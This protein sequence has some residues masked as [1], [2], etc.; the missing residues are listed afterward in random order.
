MLGSAISQVL[1]LAGGMHQPSDGWSGLRNASIAADQALLQEEKSDNFDHES[2]EFLC[3]LGMPSACDAAQQFRNETR[4]ALLQMSSGS[5]HTC[6]PAGQLVFH[7][8]MKT[9]GVSVREYLE[10]HCRQEKCGIWRDDGHRDLDPNLDA[11][12]PPAIC[13]THADY[14]DV[15]AEGRCGAAFKE[16]KHFTMLRSPVERVWSF[17]NYVKRYYKPFQERTLGSILRRLGREDLNEGLEAAESCKYCTDQLSNH[18][19]RAQ[20]CGLG[21]EKCQGMKHELPDKR[22][23]KDSLDSAMAVLGN[24]SAIFFFKEFEELPANLQAMNM[25]PRGGMGP[26]P[27]ALERSL[28]ITSCSIPQNNPTNYSAAGDR[29]KPDPVTLRLILDAN[30]ADLKLYRYSRSLPAAITVDGRIEQLWRGDLGQVMASGRHGHKVI[31]S[32]KS[33]AE[34]RDR[35]PRGPARRATGSRQSR[36]QDR[37]ESRGALLHR[38]STRRNQR[39]RDR[40]VG[41]ASNARARRV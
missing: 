1:V 6:A 27:A 3:D 19:V 13:T 17:Y 25:L 9:G 15:F 22:L 37:R 28:G 33:G 8:I 32:R 21:A 12:C 26:W 18:M 30:R 36:R 14:P 31:S 40:Q 7:H 41:K 29:E 35:A 16:A 11:T 24:M 23:L 39:N 5:E 34:R 4:D 2:S 38:L 20:F 10:C